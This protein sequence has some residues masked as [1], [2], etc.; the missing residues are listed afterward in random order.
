MYSTQ[1]NYII[2][3]GMCDRF[4]YVN[5]FCNHYGHHFSE[6]ITLHALFIRVS[7]MVM[8]IVKLE[9]SKYRGDNLQ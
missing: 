8:N 1:Q 5:G 4:A 2:V 9:L 7:Q 6:L 3:R